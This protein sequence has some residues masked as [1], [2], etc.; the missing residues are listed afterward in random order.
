MFVWSFIPMLRFEEGHN[1]CY[2]KTVGNACQINSWQ[3]RAIVPKSCEIENIPHNWQKVLFDDFFVEKENKFIQKTFL[4]K[5][6]VLL[7]SLSPLIKQIKKINSHHKD[8][9]LFMEQFFLRQIISFGL[10][11]FFVGPKAQVWLLHRYSSKQMGMKA[12]IYNFIHK[13]IEIRCGKDNLKLLCDSDLLSEDLSKVFKREVQV[14][15]IPHTEDVICEEVNHNN[16][17]KILWWPGA[18]TTKAKG[19]DIIQE[20]CQKK[21]DQF[22]LMVASTAEENL[23]HS[24]LDIL[25]LPHHLS[26]NDY[27]KNMQKADLILLPYDPKVY[28]F[29]T[30]GIFV[31][32]IVFGKIPLVH[33]DTW[34][35]YELEKHDLTKL[36][37]NFDAPNIFEIFEDVLND[38]DIRSKLLA[39]KKKYK[40]FH[41]E[42]G[43]AKKMALIANKIS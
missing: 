30:S 7:K 13:L 37:I 34:M 27:I 16:L 42:G 6:K 33:K 28:H 10:A 4:E 1:Y 24:S 22:C 35:A 19:L 18:F 9:I 32:A 5:L 23:Q 31:E 29:S 3:H 8:N 39:L 21:S 26:R 25:F 14:M 43:F 11:I 12:K 41:S 38:Q 40:D 17:K 15:P 2:N 36:I 20:L